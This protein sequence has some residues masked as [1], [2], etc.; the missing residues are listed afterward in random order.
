MGGVK[1]P[2]EAVLYG[3]AWLFHGNIQRSLQNAAARPKCLSIKGVGGGERDGFAC[4]GAD[5]PRIEDRAFHF[6]PP[7]RNVLSQYGKRDVNGIPCVHPEIRTNTMIPKSN[8]C[9]M[10]SQ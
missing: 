10:V 3:E 9:F 8:T 6:I 2:V 1:C 4:S 7:K 5:F